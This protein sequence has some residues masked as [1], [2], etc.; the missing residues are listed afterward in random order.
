MTAEAAVKRQANYKPAEPNAAA[1]PSATMTQV[2]YSNLEKLGTL[3]FELE[4]VKFHLR[5]WEKYS[6]N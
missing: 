6:N 1:S 3:E 5:A 2:S 4:R